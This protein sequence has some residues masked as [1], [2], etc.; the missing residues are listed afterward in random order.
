MANCHYVPRLLLR[1]FSENNKVN[2]YDLHTQKFARAK[3]RNVFAETDLVDQKLETTLATKLEGPFGD[4]LHHK[5]LQGSEIHLTRQEN[6]L[7]RKFCLIL[8]LR[9]PIMQLS[10]DE[11]VEKTESQDQ[12]AVLEHAFLQQFPQY[13]KFFNACGQ[14]PEHY[15][16][17]LKTALQYDDILQLLK[18][19]KDIG[20]ALHYYAESAVVTPCAF[21][22]CSET[23]LEFLLPKLPGICLSDPRGPF[24]KAGILHRLLQQKAAEHAPSYVLEEIRQLLYGSLIYADHFTVQPLSPTRVLVRFSPYFRA[25]F[26]FIDPHSG[27]ILYPPLLSDA[28][29]SSRF[30]I[31]MRKELFRPCGNVRNQ[32][33]TFNAKALTAAEVHGI[34]AMLLNMEPDAFVFHNFNRIR[35][36]LWMYDHQIQF[37]TKK[38]HDFSHLL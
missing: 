37:I 19:E 26:P 13:K 16:E 30:Y 32:N 20:K 22:D 23:G 7:M 1:P 12:P 35:D 21:W 29:F 10:W 28:Q 17:N 11:M 33:Y 24:S 38:K 34:N 2:L 18:G 5:L 31:P 6:L 25:F 3:L 14:G 15:I 36:S 9:N 27:K 8:L 4:L